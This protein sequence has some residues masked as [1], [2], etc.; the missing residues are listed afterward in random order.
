MRLMLLLGISSHDVEGTVKTL[1]EII[2][3]FGD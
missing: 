1:P 3:F 2:S